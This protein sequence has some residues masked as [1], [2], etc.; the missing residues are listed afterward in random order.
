LEKF[1]PLIVLVIVGIITLALLIPQG[2][3]S[4]AGE[5]LPPLTELQTEDV[6]VGDGEEVKAGDTVKVHYTGKLLSNGTQFDSSEGREP[7]QVT[8]GAGRVIQGWDQGIP[9]M[10]VGGRRTLKIPAKMAY[11]AGGSPPAIPPNADLVFDVKL[12]EKVK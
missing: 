10:R 3:G 4:G 8:L 5:K 12:L 11:G 7:F 9:G 2:G 6:V 1:W